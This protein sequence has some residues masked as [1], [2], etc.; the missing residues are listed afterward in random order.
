MDSGSVFLTTPGAGGLAR[1]PTRLER[2]GRYFL[3]E[4]IAVGG[5]AEVY[6]AVTHGVEGFRRTFVVKRILPEK[7]SSP[8][9]VR[10]FCDEARISALLHHPNIVQVYDFGHVRGS[11]FLAMEYLAGKDLSSLMRVL[12]AAKASVPP[13]LAAY[14]ARE[15]ATGLHYAHTL[16]SASGQPLGI[17]HRDVT[18]SNVMMLFTGGVKILD[19]GI[20]KASSAVQ[21]VEV[22]GGVK[23]KF[24]YLSPEQA[25]G[26]DLDGRADIFALGVTLWEMLAGRRL[27]AGKDDLET[28]RNVLQ[29]PVPPP[30]SIR[31]EVPP[32]LDRIVLRAL[33]RS[34]ERRYQTAEEFALDC[35]GVARD[36]RAD[37]QTMRLFLNDLFAEE[38][39][40]LSLDC[41]EIPEE[42]FREAAPE[43]E[44]S[45]PDYSAELARA[46]QSLEIEVIEA[47]GPVG[48]GRN[49]APPFG[50]IASDAAMRPVRRTRFGLLALVACVVALGSAALAVGALRTE[51]RHGSPVV[52]QPAL[53]PP[54]PT[55]VVQPVIVPTPPPVVAPQPVSAA[56]NKAE[57][58]ARRTRRVRHVGARVTIDPD[59][60]M[61]PF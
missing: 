29:K 49:P 7:A 17:V 5:M 3:V 42:L 13:G 40:S 14:V 30:S 34:P 4:R 25:R 10:M 44:A 55:I 41:P 46:D 47:S 48:R 20:A 56:S 35:D 11:Y 33:D 58:P 36:L 1:L 26:A 22:E 57:E 23:G 18:P 28:L 38:S 39:S 12:R 31:R 9:F 21:A 24:G 53:P 2:F 27:F 32:E 15:A 54:A 16:R 8:T 45:F 59:A 61:N 52:S 50:V 51:A 43:A 6:R 19:F 60:T 37:G